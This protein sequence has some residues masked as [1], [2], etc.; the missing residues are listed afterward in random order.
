MTY[1]RNSLLKI[2]CIIL[3]TPWLYFS[4]IFITTIFTFHYVQSKEIQISG[5]LIVASI[6]VFLSKYVE[7]RFLLLASFFFAVSLGIVL[8]NNRVERYL[9]EVESFDKLFSEQNDLQE[10]NVRIIEDPQIEHGYV[11]YVV[12]LKNADLPFGVAEGLYQSQKER[13]KQAVTFIARAQKFP[14]FSTGDTCQ[15]DLSI[16]RVVKISEEYRNYL[17]TEGLAGIGEF[18]YFKCKN[19]TGVGVYLT[20]R[21]NVYQFKNSF[22]KIVEGALYEPRASLLN[23]ILFGDDRLFSDE[24]EQSLRTSGSTHLIAASG[25]NVNV[26]ALTVETLLRRIIPLRARIPFILGGVWL[27]A[28]FA[29]LSG[30]IVRAALMFTIIAIL[31]LIGRPINIFSVLVATVFFV[32]MLDPLYVANIGFLLSLAAVTGLVVSLPMLKSLAEKIFRKTYQKNVINRITDI[33]LPSIACIAFTIPIS[34][35]FFNSANFLT[36][37]PNL[38]LIPLVELVFTFGIIGL[39]SSNFEIMQVIVFK[40]LDVVLGLFE[41]VIRTGGK[42]LG[43]EDDINSKDIISLSVALLIII[44]S[45]FVSIRNSRSNKIIRAF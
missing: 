8:Y 17:M 23:G 39:I 2:I 10:V 12:E 5:L 14:K 21:R 28:L 42:L 27:F 15:L 40:G 6:T 43:A 44:T 32:L 31:K 37:L 22:A 26:A 38:I 3:D 4:L 19:A 16:A 33:M 45:L 25:F 20:I 18:P 35:I 29:N 30:S 41:L 13:D 9:I 24:F 34:Y 1:P 7:A 36:L 11:D